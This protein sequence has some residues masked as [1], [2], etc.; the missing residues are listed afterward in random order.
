MNES[1]P[2]ST[3]H[4]QDI[5]SSSMTDTSIDNENLDS[6]SLLEDQDSLNQ[7]SDLELQQKAE[8][9]RDESIENSET[10]Q[11]QFWQEASKSYFIAHERGE[12]IEKNDDIKAIKL[13]SSFDCVASTR[14]GGRKEN[15]DTAAIRLTDHGLLMIVCDG[16]GGGPSGK[17]ASYMAAHVISNYISHQPKK[18]PDT[19]VLEDSILLAHNVLKFDAKKYPENFGMGT[20]AAVLLLNE[21]HAVIGHVGDSRVYQIRDGRLLR[22]TTDH[23]LVARKMQLEGWTDEE[24]RTSSESNIITQAIG[25]REIEPEIEVYSY[26]KGDRFLLCSDGIWGHYPQKQL[27]QILKRTPSVGGALSDLMV[28]TDNIGID[29]GNNHDNFTAIIVQTNISSKSKDLMTKI[30]KLIIGILGLLLIISIAC[31]IY[32]FTNHSQNQSSSENV[33][34]AG[35]KVDQETNAAVATPEQNN[36][37]ATDEAKAENRNSEEANVAKSDTLYI[38]KDGDL[39]SKI[40]IQFKTTTEEIRLANPDIDLNKISIGQSI[41]IPLNKDKK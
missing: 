37:T 35:N 24:A 5:S 21:E 41:V 4:I 7:D 29:E 38:I 28:T 32:L 8:L 1:N 9:T 19:Q 31:N 25:H 18:T 30:S 2:N 33:E 34:A 15:Q 39:I 12:L 40:A 22:R 13:T 20:T 23:S 3:N 10:T 27:L 16:M 14:I 36:I 17:R 6:R 11:E 26:L